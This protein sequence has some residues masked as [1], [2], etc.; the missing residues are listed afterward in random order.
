MRATNRAGQPGPP[1]IFLHIIIILLLIIPLVL[2][3]YGLRDTLETASPL[4]NEHHV[5]VPEVASVLLG[6][7]PLH[8]LGIEA[9]VVSDAVL[10]TLVRCREEREV[11]AG[12][13][14]W[15]WED[16]MYT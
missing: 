2:H 12:G 8:K 16:N 6:L 10:P 5:K 1:L 11:G 4:L 13:R 3:H 14:T 9:E 7:H 15:F